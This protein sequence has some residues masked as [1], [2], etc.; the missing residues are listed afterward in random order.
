MCA[1]R[2]SA[3]STWKQ[4]HK[5]LNYLKNERGISNL[6]L[7]VNRIRNDFVTFRD[8]NDVIV[9][10]SF[11]RKKKVFLS[12]TFKLRPW[13]CWLRNFIWKN[14]LLRSLSSLEIHSMKCLGKYVK[15]WDQYHP[16]SFDVRSMTRLNIFKWCHWIRFAMIEKI[17]TKLVKYCLWEVVFVKLWKLIWKF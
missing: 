9:I 11:E 16:E 6:S 7:D 10:Y 3:Y 5:S 8:P 4:L 13:L 1:E 17:I 2:D 12:Q 14:I 15:H